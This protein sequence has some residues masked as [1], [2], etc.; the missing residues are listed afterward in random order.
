M[1][2]EDDIIYIFEV[3][4]GWEELLS[5]GADESEA[6]TFFQRAQRER[7]GRVLLVI[8][9]QAIYSLWVCSVPLWPID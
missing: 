1:T 2:H 8:D 6:R 4:I 9:D 7:P 5:L 3:P